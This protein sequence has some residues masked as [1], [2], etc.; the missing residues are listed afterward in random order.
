MLYPIGLR[1]QRNFVTIEFP[2][3]GLS[4]HYPLSHCTSSQESQV[5]AHSLDNARKFNCQ[6]LPLSSKPIGG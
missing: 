5:E 4:L 2:G 1:R 6:E 3:I